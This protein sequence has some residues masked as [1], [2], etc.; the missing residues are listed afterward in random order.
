MTTHTITMALG[1]SDPDTST[2]RAHR[3]W[4]QIC[5]V[6]RALLGWYAAQTRLTLNVYQFRGR[7]A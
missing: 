1:T 7:S 4:V 5:T 2:R 6:D 3:N